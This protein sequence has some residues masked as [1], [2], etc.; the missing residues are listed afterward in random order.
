MT[1]T[2]SRHELKHG[3]PNFGERP[4]QQAPVVVQYP[5]EGEKV[6]KGHYAVRVDVQNAQS[7]QLSINNGLWQDCREAS[8]H[9]WYDW[10]PSEA[11]AFRL[12]ARG[13]D[14][15]GRIIKSPIRTCRV[16]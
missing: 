10:F 5:Q 16:V 11:G 2:K 4:E 1:M 12:A 6:Y 9:Y 14:E 7:V 3:A 15:D 8:G 13:L